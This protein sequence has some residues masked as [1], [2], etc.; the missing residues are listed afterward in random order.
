MAKSMWSIF[1]TSI[2][3]SLMFVNMYLIF[4]VAPTEQ[5]MGDIQRLFYFHVPVV[6]TS[7]ISF[8]AS[9]VFSVL[10]LIRKNFY[11]DHVAYASAETGLVFFT[12]AIITGAVW[13]K[14]VWNTWWVW[15]ANGTLTFVLWLIFI[16]Y[17]MVRTYAPTPERARKWG[18]SVSILGA[19][20]VPF[21][22]MAAD[23]WGGL[24]PERVTGPGAEGSLERSMLL[25][26]LF[27][28]ACFLSLFVY[29]LVERYKQRS[30]EDTIMKIN[31]N[32]L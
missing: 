28:F 30:I 27:S 22:Y 6:L 2:I 20:T 16:G 25:I 1:S 23:W 11:W 15:D 5:V 10:Y 17:L 24:H 4:F 21:V 29:L 19:A 26:L 14:P 31:Q 32:Y 18:A 12:G 7:F 13:A 8:F 9:A 3:A